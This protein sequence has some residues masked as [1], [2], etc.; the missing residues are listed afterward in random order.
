MFARHNLGAEIHYQ[1]IFGARAS[2]ENP[3]TGYEAAIVSYEVLFQR[4]WVYWPEIVARIKRLVSTTKTVVLLTQDDYTF[5]S[6]LDDLAVDLDAVIYSPI[7]KDLENIYPRAIL[8]GL[9][10]RSCLT[11]YLEPTYL[12][13]YERF[14]M[15]MAERSIDLGQRVSRA[16]LS[17]GALGRRKA[18]IAEEMAKRFSRSG[19]CVDVST[20][21][22]DAL[23]GTAW[24]TFLGSCKMTISRKGGASLVDPENRV[25]H[26][27]RWADF[28][29]PFI[30]EE[31]RLRLVDRGEAVHGDY[32]AESPRL[33]E[34]AAL[35]V[36]Q[37]LEEDDYLG[38]EL[39]PWHHYVPL[40]SDFSNIEE[41]INVARDHDQL[42]K[43]AAA[44][45]E[46]LIDSQNFTYESFVARIFS[47]V[48]GRNSNLLTSE[49]APKALDLDA[50]WE[51]ARGKRIAAL[52]ESLREQS[53]LT[54]FPGKALVDEFKKVHESIG[55]FE[56]I[57]ETLLL[58]W[59][60]LET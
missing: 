41:V 27:L 43:I 42:E 5:S 29:F 45:L 2:F 32:A 31:S 10:I 39:V 49:E 19:L 46:R 47:E 22:E 57:P 38:G 36:V 44:A 26:R 53:A 50:T 16:P 35:G 52:R 40:S 55:V 21:P 18:E 37:I 14:R 33:F 20:R 12:E 28:F 6:R 24:L 4:E 3:T 59:R 11:G 30:S 51:D 8:K 48:I 23:V 25:K 56:V 60:S 54:L 58:S 13:S 15:R 34:A 9:T 1:N 17:M 7:T